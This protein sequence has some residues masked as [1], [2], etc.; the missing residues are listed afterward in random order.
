MET[1][2]FSY[3]SRLLF[4]WNQ[5][6][7]FQR[8]ERKKTGII[9]K[10]G[11][12]FA[13]KFFIMRNPQVSQSPTPPQPTTGRFLL[14]APA[15][16][17]VVA[18][19]GTAE[20]ILISLVVTIFLA[21]IS[22]SPIFW[23]RQKGIPSPFAVFGVVLGVFSVGFAFL[24]IIGTS[25][26]DFSGAIP[27]YQ[28]RLTN[29]IEPTIRWIHESGFQLDK[30]LFVKS[31]DPGTSMR[32]I[33]KMLSGLGIMLTNSFCILLTVIFILFDNPWTIHL[34]RPNRMHLPLSQ[35]MPVRF[36]FVP[37]SFNGY[38]YSRTPSSLA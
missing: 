19:M 24:L 2:E 27:R 3:S 17:I 33:A 35:N 37:D 16:V 11:I 5:V 23:L 6:P 1:L 28:A 31:M 38:V 18:G 22:A 7:P 12:F 32:L 8:Q 30:S 14:T 29:E 20:F 10:E 25:L 36:P 26:D 21:I 4:L 9:P 13:I 34:R 15:F